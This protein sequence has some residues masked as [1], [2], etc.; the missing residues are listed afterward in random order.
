MRRLVYAFS[1][2]AALAVPGTSAAPVSAQTEPPEPQCAP[3]AI[4]DF[5]FHAD[6]G[7]LRYLGLVQQ[8]KAAD[9]NGDRLVCTNERT[10]FTDK[11]FAASITDN[12]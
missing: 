1:L 4:S 6:A 5:Q 3:V 2:I 7:D 9:R 10:R 8:A 12:P 11:A